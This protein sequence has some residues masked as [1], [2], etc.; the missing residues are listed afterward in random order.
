MIPTLKSADS[1][2]QLIFIRNWSFWRC[3]PMAQYH[4][5]LKFLPVI[6]GQKT[7]LTCNFTCIALRLMH[8]S[9]Q[10][11][12]KI[13]HAYIVSALPIKILCFSPNK[14]YSVVEKLV[15]HVF[16]LLWQL[17][18]IL[19]HQIIFT[20]KSPQRSTVTLVMFLYSILQMEEI[21]TMC[22]Q[23]LLF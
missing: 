14:L 21:N 9:L 12:L 1:T 11:I 4:F 22:I 23:T 5:T 19:F 2:K 10:S 16:R 17:V 6:T 3:S 7:H 18:R 15:K 8:S 13:K 20:I